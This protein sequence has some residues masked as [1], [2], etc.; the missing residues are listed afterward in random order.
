VS[1]AL[2]AIILQ[3]LIIIGM[4]LMRVFG[5]GRH[6]GSAE[7]NFETR[8]QHLVEDDE[9]LRAAIIANNAMRENDYRELRG[10]IEKYIIERRQQT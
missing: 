7:A 2:V 6:I 3:A 1:L 10:L 4:I 9:E 5:S 8:L